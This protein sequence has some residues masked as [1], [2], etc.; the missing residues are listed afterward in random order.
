MNK[1]L[2]SIFLSLCMV[3]TLLPFSAIAEENDTYPELFISFLYRCGTPHN[4]T[5]I[6]I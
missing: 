2:L 3:L 1:R 4:I 6:A 5:I